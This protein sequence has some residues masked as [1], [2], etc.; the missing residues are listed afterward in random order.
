MRNPRANAGKR[1]SLWVFALAL[2][3][4]L[5][6]KADFEDGLEAFDGGDLYAEGLGVGRDLV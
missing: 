6:S 4:A 3:W 2:L 5:A 1:L